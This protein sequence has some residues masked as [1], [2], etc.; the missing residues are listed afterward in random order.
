MGIIAGDI[1]EGVVLLYR[2]DQICDRIYML[3]QHKC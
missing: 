3:V 1:E 2:F